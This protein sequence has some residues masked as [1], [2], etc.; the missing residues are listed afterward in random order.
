[1]VN[2]LNAGSLPARLI[3]QPISE[4]VIGPS[5]GADNLHQGIVSGLIGVVAGRRSS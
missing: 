4:R 2:K 5:I 3:E 1:M